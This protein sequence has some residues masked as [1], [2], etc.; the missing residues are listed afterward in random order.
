MVNVRW[1]ERTLFDD[2]RYLREDMVSWTTVQEIADWLRTDY[3]T[4]IDHHCRQSYGI[5]GLAIVFKQAD[6]FLPVVWI[7][8]S[9]L[10]KD[11]QE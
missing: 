4:P 9:G 5:G 3:A 7:N 11:K 6:D 1:P 2:R 10:D 8:G